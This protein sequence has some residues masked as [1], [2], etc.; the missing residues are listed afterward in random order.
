MHQV[1]HQTNFYFA[2]QIWKLYYSNFA[3]T[4]SHA[5]ACEVVEPYIQRSS[6]LND[7]ET[8]VSIADLTEFNKNKRTTSRVNPRSTLQNIMRS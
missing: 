2:E 5:C 3:C 1:M 4:H 7:R 6:C 8:D